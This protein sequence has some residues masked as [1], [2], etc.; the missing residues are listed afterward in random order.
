MKQSRVN[1]PKDTPSLLSYFPDDIF[2]EHIF[3]KLNSET[4]ATLYNMA[5]DYRKMI[6]RMV[7]V[8]EHF[9]LKG[10]LF[11]A[12]LETSWR[13]HYSDQTPQALRASNVYLNSS[14]IA[15]MAE[16]SQPRI[17]LHGTRHAVIGTQS[18]PPR[19]TSNWCILRP[20]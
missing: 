20:G 19:S 14:D 2:V 6:E 13:Q 16:S 15:S 1:D 18:A 3:P 11:G 5:G 17:Q 12:M 9:I 8:C 10:S 7:N 4:A